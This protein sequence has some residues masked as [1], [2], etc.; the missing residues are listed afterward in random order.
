MTS[1]VFTIRTDMPFKPSR[2][3]LILLLLV[4]VS[5]DNR[6]QKK[7][8]EL[9]PLE[10][11]KALEAGGVQLLD[12]R[13]AEEFRSG[14]L[15]G[16]LQADWTDRQQFAERTKHLDKNRP[17]YVYCLSGGR[18]DAAAEYL[19]KQGHT[20]VVNMS[21]GVSAWKRA[22]LPI[23]SE[24][25]TRKQTSRSDYDAL[26]SSAPTVIVDFGAEWCPPCRKMEPII[27]GFMKDKSEKTVRLVKMDGGAETDLMKALRVEALPTF[28][29]YHNGIESKRLQGVMTAEEWEKWVFLKD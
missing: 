10:Y 12:C 28:I 8:D 17:V 21:G 13:T 29:L 25:P 18:S 23:E 20:E 1:F 24:D 15:K 6:A 5:C 27:N 2:I 26:A 14:H 16:A 19:R 4:A 22:D 9:P 7:R 3:A 11:A